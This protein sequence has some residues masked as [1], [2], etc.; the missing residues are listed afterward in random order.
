VLNG[1]KRAGIKYTKGD[2]SDL[3]RLTNWASGRGTFPGGLEQMGPLMSAFIF[4]PRWTIAR[5][6]LPLALLPQVTKSALVRRE[7]WRT[8]LTAVGAG[9]GIL[10]MAKLSGAADINLD[11]RSA[12][13]GKM[14]VTDTEVRL[15][16]WSGYVQYIRFMAQLATAQRQTT[17]GRTMALNRKEVIDRFVQSKLSPAVGLVNDLLKGETYLG[18]DL[19]PKSATGVLGQIYQRMM[20]LAIQDMIDGTIQDGPVGAIVSSAALLGV[21]V[22][23]YTDETRRARDQ[24]AQREY[25]MTWDEVGRQY[26]RAA[27]LRLEQTTPAILAAE[28]EQ[29]RRFATGSPTL[30]QQ[31]QNEGQ[32][33]EDTYRELVNL[34]AEEFR[35][36][37]D[38]YTFRNKVDQA[39]STRRTM[40]GSR[41]KRTE[42]QEIIAYYNQPLDPKRIAEMNPGDVL[43][44]EYYQQL[45]APDMYDE[46]GNYLFDEAEQRELAFLVKHGQQ[47]L[48]YIDEYRGSIW[49]DKPTEVE[50]LEQ[51]RETLRPYWQIADSIWSM[52][53]PELRVLS[54]Q[55][56][57][58]ERTEPE[59][60]RQMLRRYP[61]ILRAREIIARYRKQM[62][63]TNPTVQRVYRMFY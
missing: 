63:D 27:Q 22:V 9:A 47:A 46:F 16:I 21:G 18:E 43:R 41:A 24:A 15:D 28:Q 29:E 60:A 26:G 52:Y 56:R 1:W 11:P 23:T 34:A 40:Y 3:N 35:K 62:R 55:I 10:T 36:T 7:A 37:R 4:A 58:M 45:F 31:W 59:K 6:Q 49:L 44:R 48:D 2:I 25:G 20:P 50:M 13:F 17:G 54:D 57:I 39:A 30:M 14:K 19:P 32:A 51:A 5:I 8:M 38:G 12:D 53:P 42:Y 33:I 61:A